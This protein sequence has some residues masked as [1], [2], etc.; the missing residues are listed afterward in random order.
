MKEFNTRITKMLDTIW[1]DDIKMFI[2][3]YELNFTKFIFRNKLIWKIMKLCTLLSGYYSD[4][5]LFI[6]WLSWLLLK[7]SYSS[8][9]IIESIAISASFRALCI[10]FFEPHHIKL[11]IFFVSNKIGKILFKYIKEF[12]TY[13]SHI[14][15]VIVAVFDKT[16]YVSFLLMCKVKIRSEWQIHFEPYSFYNNEYL[17]LDL[18]SYKIFTP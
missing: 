6:S 9:Y 18:A 11:S 10:F 5:A 17:L 16:V 14:N 12:L 4:V 3:F 15:I 7:F 1:W 2:Q 8:F 13:I